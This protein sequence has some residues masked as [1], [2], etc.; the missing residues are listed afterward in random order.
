MTVGSGVRLHG[1][2]FL[3]AVTAVAAAGPQ[4]AFCSL[5]VWVAG[6]ICSALTGALQLLRMVCTLHSRLVVC[7]A[8][9]GL[10]ACISQ[11]KY[12]LCLTVSTR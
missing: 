5:P 12:H 1:C 3:N 9:L 2:G 8:I 7:Q 11:V 4:K 6:A 10:E